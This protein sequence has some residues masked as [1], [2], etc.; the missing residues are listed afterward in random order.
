[1]KAEI[2]TQVQ[3]QTP[4]KRKAQDVFDESSPLSG[5][6]ISRETF[7][8]N[9]AL[10]RQREARN[11]KFKGDANAPRQ[12]RS[13]RVV[14]DVNGTE[15][16]DEF[17]NDDERLEIEGN[18]EDAHV[19]V[20]EEGGV[21]ERT[22]GDHGAETEVEYNQTSPAISPLSAFARQH[23]TDILATITSQNI[24]SNPAPVVNEEQNEALQGLLKLL[25]GTVERGEGNSALLT[26][27]R[28]VG[29]TRVS[30]INLTVSSS[31]NGKDCC[32]RGQ[33]AIIRYYIQD[34]SDC[35][36]AVGA[37]TDK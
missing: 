16:V 32:P 19:Y 30:L 13:G 25:Q 6:V 12:T 4:T 7:L 24:S 28:G 5:A 11:F 26:G 17:G 10:K 8:A 21:N 18:V 20:E 9:E 37:C 36:Q 2:K 15:E 1:V 27:P 23:V 29:K 34:R 35:R 31:T 33:T 3:A 14:V 22:N